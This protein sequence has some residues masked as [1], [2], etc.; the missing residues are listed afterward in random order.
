MKNW[1]KKSEPLS[2]KALCNWLLMW[3]AW[4]LCNTTNS[5]KRTGGNR[6]KATN[7]SRQIVFAD[8]KNDMKAIER[9]NYRIPLG[10]TNE[11]ATQLLR[12]FLSRRHV[13]PDYSAAKRLPSMR[14]CISYHLDSLAAQSSAPS[15]GYSLKTASIICKL[16]SMFTRNMSMKG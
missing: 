14:A 16:M 11:P 12:S 13:T 4:S 9:R 15:R 5:W 6:C 10:E 3:T 2:D 8:E 1:T 7:T